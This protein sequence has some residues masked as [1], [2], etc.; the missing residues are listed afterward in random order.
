MA[1]DNFEQSHRQ[2]GP[3]WSGQI[4]RSVVCVISADICV[5]GSQLRMEAPKP[6]VRCPFHTRAV[7]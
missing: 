2:S 6:F 7:S 5:A 3:A 1:V 4:W